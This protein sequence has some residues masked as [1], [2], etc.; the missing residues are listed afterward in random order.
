MIARLFH[1]ALVGRFAR[2]FSVVVFAV[3]DWSPERRFIG[4]FERAFD[5]PDSAA[6]R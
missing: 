6:V 2:S 4:P 3:T 1:D 5:V